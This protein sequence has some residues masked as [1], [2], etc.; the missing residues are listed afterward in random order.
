[1]KTEGP[2]DLVLLDNVN[3]TISIYAPDGTP[4]AQYGYEVKV[5]GNSTVVPSII[6]ISVGLPG[7]INGDGKVNIFDV[8]RLL[9]Y[10]T[11]ESVEVKASPDI[12]AD[13]KN[14]VFDVVRL[15]KYVTGENVAIN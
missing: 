3:D 1:M 5:D 9:K 8:V 10:V 7:D 14:N 12:N 13:G 15:L 11:R 6:R 2:G 4:S